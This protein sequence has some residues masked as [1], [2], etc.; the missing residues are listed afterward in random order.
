MKK[1]FFILV[2]LAFVFFIAAGGAEKQQA[3]PFAWSMAL[4]NTRTD[5]S[6]P[7][8]APV[9]S[10]TG[11]K[12]R[13]IINPAAECYFYIIAESPNGEDAAIIQA[14]PLKGGEEWLSP[15]FELSP[16]KGSESFYVVA[17][18]TEKAELAR[19]IA[20]FKSNPGSAQR[21]TMMNELFRLRSE[22]SQFK[23]T[24]EKPVLMGGAARGSPGKSEGVQFSGLETYVKTISI[25]H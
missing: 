4:H 17:S 3:K 25:E 1:I 2:P 15:V 21:R 18:R 11:E 10:R 24:P 16:P 20:A 13:L 23:E 5:E 12:F 6:L 22:V 8:S 7:F 9:K 19:S 14:G